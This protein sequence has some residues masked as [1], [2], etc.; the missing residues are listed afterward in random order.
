MAPCH[1]HLPGP[2]ILSRCLI[3]HSN[4]PV[5]SISLPASWSICWPSPSQLPNPPFGQITD[6]SLGHLSGPSPSQLT[7]SPV[8]Q[9]TD[10]P[11]GHL[12]DPSPSQLTSLPV[13]QITNPSLAARPSFWSPSELTNPPVVQTTPISRSSFFFHHLVSWQ[14]HLLAISLIHLSAIIKTS[15]DLVLPVD[16]F[17]FKSILWGTF[18]QIIFP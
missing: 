7:N 6:P 9:I 5:W 1:I 13:A 11:L 16:P 12:S 15:V 18:C 4:P 2:S 3:H 14:I 10:P 17:S 8:G